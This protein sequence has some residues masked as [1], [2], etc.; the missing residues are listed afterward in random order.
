MFGPE[1]LGRVITIR[2]G[3][4]TQG[5]LAAAIGVD[6]ATMNAYERGRHRIDEATLE[7]IAMALQCNPFDLLQDAFYLF[8]YNHFRRRGEKIGVTAEELA[9]REDPRPSLDEVR[10]AFRTVGAD[11]WSFIAKILEHLQPDRFY[12]TR[13]RVPLWGVVVEPPSRAP[14]KGKEEKQQ[15]KR[16]SERD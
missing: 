5:E 16:R 3:E 10:D 1:Y 4:G 13:S 2:R 9:A 7:R 14:R 6:K 8:R 11:P 12:E 15:K